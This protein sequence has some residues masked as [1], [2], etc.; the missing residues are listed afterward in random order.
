VTTGVREHHGTVWLG[1]IQGTTVAC[2]TVPADPGHRPAQEGEQIPNAA[3]GDTCPAE[4]SGCT[5]QPER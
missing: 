5:G 1:S 4:R 3:D 2:F